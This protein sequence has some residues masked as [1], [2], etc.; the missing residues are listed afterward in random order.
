[1]CIDEPFEPTCKRHFNIDE[2]IEQGMKA[3]LMD[4]L[5]VKLVCLKAREL[6]IKE[7]NVV[8]VKYPINYK[9]NLCNY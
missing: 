8:K 5:T 1:M 2:L 3:K 6:L 9:I 7:D 4:E